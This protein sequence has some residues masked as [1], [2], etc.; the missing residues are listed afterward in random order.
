MK[1]YLIFGKDGERKLNEEEF[2]NLLFEELSNHLYEKIESGYCKIRTNST[3]KNYGKY[4][5]RRPM[6]V[7]ECQATDCVETPIYSHSISKNAV[8][9]NIASNGMVYTP[10]IKNDIIIMGSIGIE[11]QASV[12]PYFCNF[13]DTKYFSELDK[14]ERGEYS[15]KFFEQLIH[16]TIFREFYVLE[17]NIE[18]ANTILNEINTG[19]QNVKSQTISLHNEMIG[20]KK[21]K[22]KDWEDSRFS[23]SE[24]KKQIEDQLNYDKFCH[25]RLLDFYS[26][27][28]P[29][30]VIAA[31]IESTLPVAF[32][33][34][35][36]FYI[37]DTQINIVINCLPY[38]DHTVFSI[39][40]TAKDDDCIK[41]EILSKYDLENN[42]SLL[43]FIEVL[44]VNGTDNIFFDI[45]FWDSIDS[46]ISN[47]YIQEFSNFEKTDPRNKIDFSFLKWNY[48]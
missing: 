31:I 36:K 41:S 29:D 46:K 44:T 28:K 2:T 18:M 26:N 22:V 40:N 24:N 16:R 3:Y 17:R 5:S 12:F 20:L 7:G 42:N 27:Q 30:Q 34:L 13:H 19:F 47:R 39:A 8:L 1:E 11:T 4:Y 43:K 45:K 33:G 10:T 38:K 6:P 23:L 25:N 15:S 32:S 14:V 37:N 9:K 21:H 48:K 35:T